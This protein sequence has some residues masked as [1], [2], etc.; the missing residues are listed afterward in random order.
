MG[1]HEELAG[2]AR[3]AK[4]LKRRGVRLLG[5]GDYGFI[6]TPHGKNAR[7]LDH[8]VRYF[9]FTPMESLLTMTK[10][11]GEAM[12]MG[13]ELGQVREG[14]LADLLLVQGNPLDDFSILLERENL[15]AIMKDGHLHKAPV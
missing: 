9:D 7:D 10:F 12:D 8:F 1:F 3:V 5:G 6:F 11:G 4:E 2:A 14:F 15:L 13:H